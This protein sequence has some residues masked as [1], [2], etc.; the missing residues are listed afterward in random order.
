M[1]RLL[2]P[3]VTAAALAHLAACAQPAAP[4]PG[5]PISKEAWDEIAVTV[6]LLREDSD[7]FYATHKVEGEFVN[8]VLKRLAQEGFAC[9]IGYVEHLYTSPQQPYTLR[10][11]RIPVIF[12]E[13]SSTEAASICNERRVTFEVAWQD[14]TVSVAQLWGQIDASRVID[15]TYACTTRGASA[16]GALPAR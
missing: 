8:V 9:R 14:A 2:R 12:C 5:K 3:V 7:R 11:K 6:K 13:Q 1:L 16:A 15:Q 10:P 4:L